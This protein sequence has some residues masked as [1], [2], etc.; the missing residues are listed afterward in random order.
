MQGSE[1]LTITG[2]LGPLAGESLANTY[3]PEGNRGISSTLSVT[4]PT[5]AGDSP[6]TSLRQYWP[7]INK[8]LRLALPVPQAAPA[9]NKP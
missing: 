5:W 9:P 6:G 2:L 4:R 3:F 7:S 1:W 8:K